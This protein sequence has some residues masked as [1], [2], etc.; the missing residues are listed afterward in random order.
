VS[1]ARSCAILAVLLAAAAAFA[2]A[3][4]V[5][6]ADLNKVKGERDLSW[7]LCVG[8]AHAGMELHADNMAQ[9][10]EV[11]RELGFEY[12]RFHGIFTDDMHV[13]TE[14]NGAPV[15]DFSRVDELYD[16]V[17]AAGLKPF[18]ELSFMP[19]ALASGKQS[20]FFWNA[21][22]T[23]PADMRKWTGL[24][25]AF[26]AHLEARYGAGQVKTWYFEVWNEPNYA[27][28]WPNSDQA[29]YFN[30]YD[31][32]AAAIKAVNPAFRVGGPATAGAGWVPEFLAHTSAAKVPV[33]FV[34]THTYAVS[35]GFLDADGNADLVLSS[36]PAAISGD[37]KNVRSQID[38]SARPGLPLHITEWSASY[39]S[40][41]PVHDSYTSAAFVLE[42]LRQTEGS[43]SSM[44]YWTYSDLFEE[45]GPPPAAFH[46]GFGLLTRDDL[47]KP[48]FFAYKYLNELGPTELEDDDT[49][50][51]I[52]RRGN[53]V[54]ALLWQYTPLPQEE[55]DKAFYR[56]P[57][58]TGPAAPVDLEIGHL[59]PGSYRLQVFRTGYQANDAYSAYIAM[60]L[61]K[62]LTAEQ[63]HR[64]RDVTD[65]AAES[66]ATVVIGRDGRL[67]KRIQ[68]KANDVVFVSLARR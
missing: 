62:D 63:L 34:S 60:G 53:D 54:Q 9:L 56:R 31:A 2:Q 7:R 5:I 12:V 14:R 57:H 16:K 43:A 21:N 48:V 42:K 29:A 55:G 52:T 23:P 26:V 24:V 22:V 64:L 67:H 20:I 6:R 10:A 50:S 49:S 4:R 36:D 13:Y 66:T 18:V 30:L 44:S 51:W 46:G 58:P 37:V 15:Y 28:F 1:R 8:S 33:D 65:D 38:A 35:A 40:R 41:D 27:G 11:H 47:R 19:A 68:L 32:T 17:L 25:H 45:N 3:Q 39:S 59:A 61:P